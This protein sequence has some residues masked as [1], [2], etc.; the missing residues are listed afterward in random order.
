MGLMHIYAESDRPRLGMV[1]D[2]SN[3]NW[4]LVKAE[5]GQPRR[6][7]HNIGDS[8]FIYGRPN[9]RNALGVRE[10][11]VHIH[12][13][14]NSLDQKYGPDFKAMNKTAVIKHYCRANEQR[15][16]REQFYCRIQPK[17]TL[18]TRTK[19]PSDRNPHHIYGVEYPGDPPF[20]QIIGGGFQNE[21]IDMNKYLKV[22]H[23]Q[24]YNHVEQRF[25]VITNKATNLQY[26]F[27]RRKLSPPPRKQRF[28]LS[29]FKNV[30]KRIDNENKTPLNR[31]PPFHPF[32]GTG[33]P[34]N[35]PI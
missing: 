31:N 1:R 10:V 2:S 33:S 6:V 11:I 26:H 35:G 13:V 3:K 34:K 16:A 29:K 7:T 14:P 17:H 23:P 19:L 4:N 5:L 12:Q 9:E 32:Y 22:K 30:P 28:I 27:T 25:E 18:M 15:A 24:S 20:H 21:W 8:K